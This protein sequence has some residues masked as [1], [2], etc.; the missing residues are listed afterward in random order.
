M[1]FACSTLQAKT[2]RATQSAQAPGKIKVMFAEHTLQAENLLYQV[3][4]AP[5][6]GMS[7]VGDADGDGHWSHGA[8]KLKSH[9]LNRALALVE[10]A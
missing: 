10:Y 2:L 3:R 1:N 4:G 7:R 6:K 8:H 5:P 9:M